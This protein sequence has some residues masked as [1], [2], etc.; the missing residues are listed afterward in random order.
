MVL[1]RHTRHHASIARTR[2]H[3]S[4]QS[5]PPS[6]SNVA[7]RNLCAAASDS[8]RERFSSRRA[9][10]SFP[11]CHR[12]CRRAAA[13]LPTPRQREPSCSDRR[14]RPAAERG[15]RS[16]R[17]PES[18]R[19]GPKR[20]TRTLTCCLPAFASPRSPREH[21]RI[22]FVDVEASGRSFFSPL[23][24]DLF[25]LYFFSCSLWGPRTGS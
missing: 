17:E 3:C 4:R 9:Q 18:R 25:L 20:A 2:I 12:R 24:S 15:G 23:P 21:L 6:P 10:P 16:T 22:R 8:R 7:L 14:N 19:T 11:C 1:P 13:R 5:F